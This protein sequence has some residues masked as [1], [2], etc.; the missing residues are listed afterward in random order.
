[1]GKVVQKTKVKMRADAHCP[2]HS[3]ADIKVRDTMSYIDEPVARGGT[4][5]GPAPTEA[6]LGALIACTNVI[7]H[8][9]ADAIGIEIGHLDISAVCDF[10]RRGVTLSEVI[11][12]PFETIMLTVE[13]DGPASQAELE[14][15]AEETAKYCPLSRLFR[16]AGTQI[17]E[18]WRP[19]SG[20]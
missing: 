11:G 20:D 16:E 10:D 14:R 13:A 3:R 6:A 19:K 7:G 12:N 18:T 1:M 2:S 5:T 9:C 17:D 4:N 8:K 15:V